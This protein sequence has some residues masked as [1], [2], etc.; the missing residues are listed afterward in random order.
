MNT[1]FHQIQQVATAVLGAVLKKSLSDDAGIKTLVSA[2][3][4]GQ[5]KQLLIVGNTHRSFDDANCIAILNPDESLA[6]VINLGVAYTSVILKEIV[7]KRC[8]AMLQL[9]MVGK[10]TYVTSRYCAQRL[11]PATVAAN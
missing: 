1:D 4:N 2:E 11:R 5:E 8:D 10:N 6:S 3:I 9:Q 7:A